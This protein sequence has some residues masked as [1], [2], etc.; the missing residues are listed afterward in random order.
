MFGYVRAMKGV[1]A[2]EEWER[3]QA[4]YCGLCRCLG[5]RYGPIPPLFL[6]YDFTF[7]AMLLARDPTTPVVDCRR[8]MVCPWRKRPA[9]REDDGLDQAADASVILTWWKLRDGAVDEGFWRGLGA[10]FLSWI[11]WPSYR[12]ARRL[13]PDF[14]ETVKSCLAQLRRLEEEN[15]PSLDRPADTFARILRGAAPTEGPSGRQ[16]AL[17]Q[18]LYHVGR[19][20][21]LI[22]AWDDWT[23]DAASGSY[24][25]FLAKFGDQVATHREEVQET[26]NASLGMAVSAFVWLDE[27]V[28]TPV[29]E[30][31]LTM[32]L[33][34]MEEAVL[35]GAWRQRK[36]KHMR[37]IGDE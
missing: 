31:I 25:P 17:G 27:G 21:Y 35:S 6:N 15:C 20:I 28:W 10:R 12:K 16:Q 7:L 11:L 8:C 33:P 22:D 5:R 13:R 2:E 32:G 1:L 3:Y 14:D 19:W 37:S 24:N 18:I 4:A 29:L 36:S 23:E 26:L 30:H 9:W 34:G